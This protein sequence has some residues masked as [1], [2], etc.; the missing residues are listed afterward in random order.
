[1]NLNYEVWKLG[2]NF[3]CK[4]KIDMLHLQTHSI[5]D[6]ILIGQTTLLETKLA[7]VVVL[8]PWWLALSLVQRGENVSNKP[9]T[10]PCAP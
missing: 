4:T 8:G 2:Y 10:K 7:K 9:P 6:F 1:M 5:M 3:F